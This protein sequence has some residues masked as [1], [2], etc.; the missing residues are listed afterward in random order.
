MKVLIVVHDYLPDHLGGTELHA[1]QVA[2]ELQQRGHSVVS[3]FT[4]RRP[5]RPEGEVTEGE[6]DGVRTLEMSHS[7]EYGHVRE[8][9]QPK[10]SAGVFEQIL[11]R[12][13]PDVIHFHHLAFWGAECLSVAKRLGVPVVVTLH[14][15]WTICDAATLL[16]KNGEVCTQGPKRRCSEC[17]EWYPFPHNHPD[18]RLFRYR[19]REELRAR[20]ELHEHHLKHVPV[21]IAPSRFLIDKLIDAGLIVEAQAKVL[22][23]GYPGER[24]AARTPS[25]TGPLRLGYVG[26]V[27]ES[28]GVHVLVEAM[29]HL[30]EMGV[31][32]TLEIFGILDWFPDY[33]ERL[34]AMADGLPVEFRGRYEPDQ[35]DQV[36]DRFDALVVPSVWY[37]NMPIT[38]HEAFRNGLPVLAS[39]FGGMAEAVVEGRGGRLFPRGDA[40]ALAGLVAELEADRPQLERLAAASPPV[41]ELTEVVD[42]LLRVYESVREAAGVRA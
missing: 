23:T 20:F 41:P 17:I 12:E 34:R 9:F 10:F 18:S 13:R 26:G 4:E 15:Y 5:D 22:K 16:K 8:T 2:M 24:R 37:E 14:D 32:A 19:F 6:L 31:S 42:E 30:S 11:L 28:K 25:S 7:R 3:A 27:Y 21:V 36:L 29:G 40:R 1:H 35:V 33:V 38:I 39:N